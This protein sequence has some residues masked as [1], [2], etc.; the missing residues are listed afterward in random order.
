MADPTGTA[1]V[2]DPPVKAASAPA[3]VAAP[4]PVV[5][6][7][8]LA[9]PSL[10]QRWHA[11][12]T[13]K[14][15]AHQWL[16][17][18]LMGTLPVRR[19]LEVGPYLGLVT[20]MLASAGYEVT[21][22]DIA[23]KPPSTLGARAHIQGDLTALDPAR[24]RGFDAILCCETLEHLPWSAVGGVLAAFAA[25]GAPY[26]VFSVPY[27]GAQIGW[28][29]YANWHTIRHRL[30][31]RWLRFTQKFRVASESDIDAHKW[32]V[33]YKGYSLAALKDRAQASG[34]QPVEQ[35]F[36]EGCRSVFLVCR[37]AVDRGQAT[38]DK[39]AL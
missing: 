21:T 5:V 8:P 10:T 32:E 6:I 29:F 15:I 33:G 1:L 14:R 12:Y 31:T 9:E 20:A 36:T 4:V 13:E 2:D 25:S 27:E 3:A 17:V 24:I 37:N 35:R 30:F 34:W 38:D 11:Y 26:L 22:F 18:H 7:P 28:S 16:Q 19:V 23:A 39:I